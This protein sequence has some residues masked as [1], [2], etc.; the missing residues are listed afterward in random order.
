MSKSTKAEKRIKTNAVL[1]WLIS[2][3]GRQDIIQ[4][5]SDKWG[6]GER[7]IDVYIK[8]A[9]KILREK[10]NIDR[11]REVGLAVERLTNLYFECIKGSKKDIRTALAVQRE[12]S[13]TFGIK[14]DRHALTDTEGND[15]SLTDLI[16]KANENK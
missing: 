7:Q 6:I 12:L 4:Y 10:S 14:I 1:K 8:W 2:G 13:E 3:V 15:I 9:N 11:N 16:K 5:G